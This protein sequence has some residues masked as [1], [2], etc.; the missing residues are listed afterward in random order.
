MTKAL[1]LA[2]RKAHGFILQLADRVIVRW[3]VER[4]RA[5]AEEAGRD[6]AGIAVCVAAP[7]YLGV[8]LTHARDQCRW[9]GGIDG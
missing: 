1:A 9:F 7:A 4:V 6:P 3:T 5:A 2:R 8:D